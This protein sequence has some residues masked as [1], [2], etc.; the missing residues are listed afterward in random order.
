MID[1]LLT[2]VR[3][4][5]RFFRRSPGF[6]LVAALSLGLGLGFNA[7]LFS[8]VDAVLLRPLPVASPDT[9]VH[10]FTSGSDGDPY[11]TSSYP[12]YLDLRATNDVFDDL[13]GH[14][15]MFAALNEAGRMRLVMGEV[16]TGN[17]FTALGV[18]AAVGRTLLP[19]D[20]RP[21][22][23]RAAMV[24][25]RFWRRE[26]GADPAVVGRTL[27][28]RG[29]TYEIV[30]VAAPG[31]GGLLPMLAAE[32]WVPT[33][34]VEDVEPAGIQDA[35][36]SPTGTSRVDRRGQRWLFLKGR[37]KP[38]VSAAQAQANLDVVMA[39][40]ASAH[41][42]TN[43]GRT[44]TVVPTR[45]SRFHPAAERVLVPIATGL[46]GL[47]GLVLLV[48]CA[49]VASML[50]ARASARHRE[51]GIRLAIGA[52]RLQI[53][54]QLLIE[55]MVLSMAGG[56]L[57]VALAAVL[58][59]LATSVELPLPV[60]LTFDLRVD[61]RVLAFSVALA[62]V[63]G[64]LAG[65]AP[66][67]RTAR[68][69]VVT[70]LRGDATSGATV[71]GRRFTM[72]DALVAAQ[73]AVTLVLLVAAGLVG[74]SL[75]AAKAADVG[76]R[77]AGLAIV[78][79]DLEMIGYGRDDARAFYG[80]ALERLRALPGVEGAA[81]AERLPFSLNFNEQQFHVPG[82]VA[83]TERGFTIQATRVSE[84]YFR[85]LGVPILEG[86]AFGAVDTP[87][88][89]AVVVVNETLARRFWPGESALGKRM[90]LRGADGPAFE[91][92]GVAAD[93]RVRTVGEGLTPY[94]HF[95]QSQRSS[96]Y[97]NI[98]LRTRGDAAQALAS[99]RQ[100]L[101]AIEPNLV[102][103]DNQT[104][105][106]QI[107]GTLLPVRFAA[108][109]AFVVGVVALVIAAVGLYGVVSY[110]VARR[111]REIGVRLAIGA[112]RVSVIALVLRQGL[113]LAAVGLVA[114]GLL[115]AAGVRGAASLLYGVGASDPLA[116][117]GAAAVLVATAVLANA[118][119]AWRAATLDPLEALRVE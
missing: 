19:E 78:S 51:I 69:D 24:S 13:V 53:V 113:T 70:D 12:D 36:P 101:A 94:V 95:A 109:V 84:D 16:V 60:P 20:D 102:F 58:I 83:P 25:D 35:V 66:A 21:G 79:T 87:D 31:F 103:M 97:Q 80:R 47:V 99:M 85:T 29:Q 64:V 41:P 93:H 34:W 22:A 57:G 28:L 8:I 55:G 7:A 100:A 37:L 38:G 74:R 111:T 9:L 68:T 89:P 119:P 56:V 30:G 104:M 59:R 86:R 23:P 45:Q 49:N 71:A 105:E 3:Y 67:L 82:H 117:A 65:L 26:L 46:M 72:R 77:T 62:L 52:S 15:A 40:L 18:R 39:G 42:E 11:A 5:L 54:R 63:A 76:F 75:L 1:G 98:V 48:A 92:V 106:G 107:A 88:S 73:M 108:I 10:V 110:T 32:V 33:A 81:L 4:A 2:D 50:L 43:Q 114:G 27:R 115:A 91:V 112:D 6:V 118:V 17:Y 61:L 116:W 96:P 90:H 44:P 14:S